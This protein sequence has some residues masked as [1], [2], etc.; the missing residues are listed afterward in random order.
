MCHQLDQSRIYQNTRANRVKDAVH[1][2]GSL[3][4][5]WIAVAQGYTYSDGDGRREAITGSHEIRRRVFGGWPRHCGK[6]GAETK[7]FEG[8]VEYED[9]IEGFE[10][11]TGDGKGEADEDGVEDHAELRCIS[12][13]VDTGAGR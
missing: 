8:L 5:W 7:A 10:L 9:D 13:C 11:G 1:Y 4:S 6:T 2:E 12:V 3:R